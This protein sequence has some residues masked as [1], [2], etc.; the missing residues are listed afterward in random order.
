MRDDMLGSGSINPKVSIIMPSLNVKKY[1]DEC[2]KSVVNQSLKEIEIICVD[3]GSTDGTIEI[4]KN[5]ACLDDRIKVINSE[6]KSYGYQ[7]NIGIDSATGEYI[8]VVETD[9]YIDE[10]MFEKLYG[11]ARQYCLDV[12][13]ADYN[14]F[15]GDENNRDFVYSPMF[16]TSLADLY[17]KVASYEKDSRI[18]DANM[19][20]WAGIYKHEFLIKYNIRHNES[21]GASFQDTG[22]WIQIMMNASRIMYVDEPYYF[23]R[24]DNENSSVFDRKKIKCLS[25]EYDYMH[26]VILNS[27]CKKKIWLQILWNR[28]YFSCIWEIKRAR[29]ND[30]KQVLSLSSQQLKKAIE[31][32]ELYKDSTNKKYWE[33]I[34]K[35][36]YNPEDYFHENYELSQEII[37]KLKKAYGIYIFGAG[38]YAQRSFSLLNGIDGFDNAFQGFV[39]TSLDNNP[40]RLLHKKVMPLEIIEPKENYYIIVGVSKEK[41]SEVCNSLRSKGFANIIMYG[42]ITI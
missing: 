16:N 22:F 25:E 18:L 9:D 4:I 40:A 28:R 30:R 39:V 36:A 41:E 34:K 24:R 15:Y 17:W 7:M 12:V 32:G 37:V 23:L 3:A 14:I 11:Y 35:I 1:I 10:K 33:E 26:S 5:Y 27:K 20:T 6:Y 29:Y 38:G 19:V 31:N 2:L 21:L 8:G 13:K 42:E